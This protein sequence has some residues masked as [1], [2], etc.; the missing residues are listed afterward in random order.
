LRTK[1]RE[2]GG[3]QQQWV[4]LH[5][6]N[7]ALNDEMVMKDYFGVVCTLPAHIFVDVIK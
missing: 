2:S 1:R 4:I 3:D 7:Q 5:F 6:Y